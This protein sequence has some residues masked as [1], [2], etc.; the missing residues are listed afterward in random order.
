M[1]VSSC[2][3]AF[4]SVGKRAQPASHVTCVMG[5]CPREGEEGADDVKSAWPSDA[6]GYTRGTMAGTMG[7][8]GV[9][10]SQSHQ[11]RSQFG[12]RSA[13]RPHEAGIASKRQ[14]AMWR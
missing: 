7:C 9:S 10:R 6:L 1:V 2:R 4:P 13:T 11:S 12:L 8:E 3:E 5:D 14:S